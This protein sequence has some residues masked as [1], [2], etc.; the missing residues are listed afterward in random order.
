M[1]RVSFGLLVAVLLVIAAARFTYN[2]SVEPEYAQLNEAWAQN[3]MEFV[4]WNNEKWS[5]WIHANEFAKIPQNTADWSRHSNAS[6]AYI[7]WEG[8]SWQAK[9][10]GDLF[11]LAYQ[12]NWQG[13]VD[14]SEAIR[15]RDWS[16]NNRIRTVTELRR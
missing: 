9:I 1:V 11:L 14:Q 10:D 6:L 3:K 5:A 15:F 8:E 12:G 2:V 13:P 7:N 16:G 4:A